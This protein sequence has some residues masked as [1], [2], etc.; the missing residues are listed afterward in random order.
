MKITVIMFGFHTDR[1]FNQNTDEIFLVVAE[2]VV[3]V[4]M[5]W[6][7]H[8]V[9]VIAPLNPSIWVACGII[10]NALCVFVASAI[11]C[12]T[13]AII[14][15]TVTGLWQITVLVT[16]TVNP[17][18]S[19]VPVATVLVAKWAVYARIVR[20]TIIA[21]YNAFAS[22]RAVSVFLVIIARTTVFVVE[23]VTTSHGVAVTVRWFIS[24]C[25]PQA[26]RSTEPADVRLVPVAVSAIGVL[27]FQGDNCNDNGDRYDDSRH[28][29]RNWNTTKLTCLS[30][31]RLWLCHRLLYERTHTTGSSL[32]G[33][34]RNTNVFRC[35]P[36]K[37]AA[38]ALHMNHQVDVCNNKSQLT[39]TNNNISFTD[40]TAV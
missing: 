34:H 19:F 35:C 14:W 18:V 11:N 39:N 2:I 38:A 12:Q 6:A 9:T 37:E 32:H 31:I 1:T 25:L 5:C 13:S 22:V 36:C 17:D 4:R 20:I 10:I 8:V 24:V 16:V 26:A 33:Q 3:R 21:W 27:A 15:V 7:G 23:G 30:W 29:Q 28:R 40:C